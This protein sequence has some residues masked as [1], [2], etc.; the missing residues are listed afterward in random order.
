MNNLDSWE[1]L[2]SYVKSKSKEKSKNEEKNAKTLEDVKH[3]Q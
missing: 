1:E 3:D 2:T